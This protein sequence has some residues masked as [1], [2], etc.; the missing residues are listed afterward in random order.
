MDFSEEIL[1]AKRECVARYI[2]SAEK[3]LWTKNT[4]G[5]A[6][7]QKLSQTKIEGIHHH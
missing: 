1:Q 6:V 7:L 3:Q 5:E 4:T 2:Q